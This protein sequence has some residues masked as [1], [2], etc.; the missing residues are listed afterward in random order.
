MALDPDLWNDDG[1]AKKPSQEYME[2]LG[3][4]PVFEE[5][6]TRMAEIVEST[7]EVHVTDKSVVVDAGEAFIA[8]QAGNKTAA[9][10]D[11][12]HFWDGETCRAAIAMEVEGHTA[13]LRVHIPHQPFE[14]WEAD[15]DETR[16]N[17]GTWHFTWGQCS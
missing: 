17:A 6:V 11:V 13:T 2:R 8:F 12:V 16:E 10:G 5:Y 7:S 1:T 3:E 15:H 14:D 4:H 9:I